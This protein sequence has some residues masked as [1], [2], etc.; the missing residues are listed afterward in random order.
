MPF[1]ERLRPLESLGIDLHVQTSAA[2]SAAC[3]DPLIPAAEASHN[4]VRSRGGGGP[5][6]GWAL[7]SALSIP[8]EF[9]VCASPMDE[10]V[11]TI[12]ATNKTINRFDMP[13]LASTAC[14]R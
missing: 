11:T 1:L 4:P 13:S 12:R 7:N 10:D 6:S 2:R 3:G 9:Q 8:G 14:S 5:P